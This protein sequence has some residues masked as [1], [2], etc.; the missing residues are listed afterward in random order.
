MLT[1]QVCRV[2]LS[3]SCGVMRRFDSLHSIAASYEKTMV[4]FLAH[5]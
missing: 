5:N 4:L 1:V 2:Y 3:F